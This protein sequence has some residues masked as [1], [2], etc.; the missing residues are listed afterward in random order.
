[1]FKCKKLVEGFKHLTKNTTILRSYQK[2]FTL[3]EHKLVQDE[4]TRWNSTVHMLKRLLEQK[5]AFMMATSSTDTNCAIGLTI[6]DWKTMEV[7]I[8]ILDIF[9]TAKL[10]L[11]KKMSSISEVILII[12]NNL[13]IIIGLFSTYYIYK[14]ISL[15]LMLFSRH[16]VFTHN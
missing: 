4:P 15:R 11:S 8:E 7:T 16:I 14:L 5:Q 3:S 13:L 6:E 2:Q 10:Q 1:M 12:C 9:D